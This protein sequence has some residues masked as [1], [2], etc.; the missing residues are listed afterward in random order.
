MKVLLRYQKAIAA[1]ITGAIGWGFVVVA[2]PSSAITA[3]EW[4]AL[5]VAGATAL[6]VYGVPNVAP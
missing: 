6:G 5:A 2:S 1:I 4:M 3:S